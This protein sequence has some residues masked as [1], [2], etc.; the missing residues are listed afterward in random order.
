MMNLCPN[1]IKTCL[2]SCW[3]GFRSV[4]RSSE[5]LRTCSATFGN[6]RKNFCKSLEVAGAFWE[7]TVMTGQKSHAF[8]CKKVDR[9]RNVCRNHLLTGF[10]KCAFWISD[11]NSNKT[12]TF[13][14]QWSTE[15]IQWTGS[16]TTGYVGSGSKSS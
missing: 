16:S 13:L 7:I 5:H 11:A 10:K 12:K 8:D 1:T 4:Q 3:I 14:E 6:F 9:C 15:G 2:I